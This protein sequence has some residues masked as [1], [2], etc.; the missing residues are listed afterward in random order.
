MVR[1]TEIADK[2]NFSLEITNKPLVLEKKTQP[3]GGTSPDFVLKKVVAAFEL[4]T[5]P[6]GFL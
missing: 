5:G 6:R 4:V 3:G 2:V 1:S